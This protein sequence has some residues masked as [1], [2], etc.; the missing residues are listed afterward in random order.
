MN[1]RKFITRATAWA[2]SGGIF[3]PKLIQASAFTD[4]VREYLAAQVPKS[5]GGSF[6]SG[7]LAD[8]Q[9]N[10]NANDSSGNGNNGTLVGSPSFTTGQNSA[11]NGAVSLNGSSQYV[12]FGSV[13]NFTSGSFTI[14]TWVNAASLS[15]DGPV[16]LGNGV[17][18]VSGYYLQ[19][20]V[21]GQVLFGCET[22][23]EYITSTASGVV[24]TGSWYNIVVVCT[25]GG[26]AQI[27]INGVASATTQQTIVGVT[28][29]STSFLVGAY[30]SA[31]PTDYFDGYVDETAIWASALTS[32]QVGN[33]YSGNAR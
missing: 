15:G 19:V 10:N 6:P 30:D 26:Q 5:G 4:N 12:N 27:Y 18:H 25:I 11:A 29:A 16:I 20:L 22:S 13:G 14:S 23:T 1:R 31:S 21:G 9:F 3:V 28:S 7:S 33:I 2:L 17:Y 8:W 32:T 24:S